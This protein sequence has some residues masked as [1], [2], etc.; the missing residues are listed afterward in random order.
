M[1]RDGKHGSTP[2]EAVFRAL[3]GT[4]SPP[5]DRFGSQSPGYARIVSFARSVLV[6]ER[7]RARQASPAAYFALVQPCRKA[8]RDRLAAGTGD[9]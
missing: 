6:R 9:D 1:N 2:Y 7:G 4:G 5:A 3:P 8:F